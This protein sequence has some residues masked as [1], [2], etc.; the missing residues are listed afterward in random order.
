VGFCNIDQPLFGKSLQ[1]G[2]RATAP[3]GYVRLHGRNYQ[4]WFSSRERSAERYDYLYSV[5]E[6]APWVERIKIIAEQA[7]VTYVVANN[8]FEGKGV[9][10]ALQLVSLITNQRV[11]VPATLKS[12]YRELESIALPET[13]PSAPAQAGLR[14]ESASADKEN[15]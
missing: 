9:T 7:Q 12:H 4:H 5:E 3:V 10:N 8:H 13:E 14:F 1:P 2:D 15:P 6:L 11:R